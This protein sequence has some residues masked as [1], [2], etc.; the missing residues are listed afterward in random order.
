MADSFCAY[1]GYQFLELIVNK[2]K[3]LLGTDLEDG[4]ITILKHIGNHL[5]YEPIENYISPKTSE[6]VV[7]KLFEKNIFSQIQC[8]RYAIDWSSISLLNGYADLN[9]D[10]ENL[11]DKL[12]NHSRFDIYIELQPNFTLKFINELFHIQADNFYSRFIRQNRQFMK[13]LEPWIQNLWIMAS[14]THGKLLFNR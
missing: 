11:L 5:H 8:I 14:K 9:H 7:F 3:I 6:H 4:L 13:Y 10:F 2:S 12:C 1:E